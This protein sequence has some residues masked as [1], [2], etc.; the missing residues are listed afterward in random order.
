MAEIIRCPACGVTNR[1]RSDMRG[2]PLCGK[3][4]KPLPLADKP[5]LRILTTENFDSAIRL[6]PQPVLV[7]FWANWCLPCRQMAKALEKLAA[8]QPGITVAKVDTDAEPGLAS[9]FQIFSIPTLIMFVKGREVHRVSGAMNES[10]LD[11]AFRPWLQ[12]KEAK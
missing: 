7:D 10:E 8:A 9:Q 3:C 11:K 12:K 2:V 1:V 6:N 5:R 4:K